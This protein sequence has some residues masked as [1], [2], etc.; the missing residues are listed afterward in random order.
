MKLV[1]VKGVVIRETAYSDNDKIITLLTDSLG[2]ISCMA[3]G[4]KKTNSPILA[5]SQYLVYSEFV[6]Y[7]GT[8]FYYINSAD[9]VNTFYDLRID[10]DKLNVAFELT[11]IL[12]ITT[13]ENQDTSDVLKLFLNTLY[14]IEKLNKDLELTKSIFKVKL[15]NL[16][17][18]YQPINKCYICG[19]NME[20]DDNIYYDYVTNTY[21]CN[22]CINKTD[23]RRYIEISNTCVIAINY[24][25]RSGIKKVFSFELKQNALRQFMLY[26]QAYCDSITNGI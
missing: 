5:S 14:V 18:F 15:L 21:L 10:L 16:L 1:K 26:A 12:Q 7:K 2:K 22:N 9:V 8:S 20:N 23:K 3:K 4:A 13:D 11:K 24:V 19:N 25:A 17:G 6:L